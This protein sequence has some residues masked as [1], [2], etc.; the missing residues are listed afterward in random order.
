MNTVVTIVGPRQLELEQIPDDPLGPGRAR[1]RTLYSGISAGTELTAYRGTNP[2]LHKRWNPALRLFEAGDRAGEAY[3]LR[4]WGYEEVGEVVEVG[5]GVEGLG[6]G[7]PVFGTWGHRSSA[8]PGAGYL[9]DRVL[10][11]ELEPLLGIFSHIGSIALTGIHDAEPRVGETVAV[12]GIGVLGQIVARLAKLAGARVIGVDLDEK[13]LRLALEAGALDEAVN[14]PAVNTSST[15]VSTRSVQA[16]EARGTS[17]KGSG[18][19]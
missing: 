9:G 13:R 8:V 4:G 7:T 14:A 16:P 19:R 5:P 15:G 1:V 10:P 17:S 12:F 11:G 6:P 18:R 2:Y 3:P